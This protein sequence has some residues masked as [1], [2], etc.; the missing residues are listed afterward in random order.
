[1]VQYICNICNKEFVRKKDLEYH[2]IHK[3]KPCRVNNILIQNNPDE[4]K[5]IQNKE[6]FNQNNQNKENNK[7]FSCNFCNKIFFN[8]SNLNKHLKNNSCKV[9]KLQD[10]EKE[11]IFKILLAKDEEL[12]TQKEF[13]KN[14]EENNKELKEYIKNITNMNLDLNNKVNKLIEKI[15]VGNIN[16]GVINNNNNNINNINN[17]IITTDQLCNFGS[18]DIKQIDSKLFKNLNGKF[19]K[20]IFLECAKNIYNNLSKNKTLYFSDLSREKAMAWDNG[21]WNLIPMNKAINTINDQIRAYFKHNEENYERL[22][23]PEV[24]KHYDETI[25]KYYKMYYQEYDKTDKFEPAQSRLDEFNRV[26]LN[27]LK[28]FFYNIKEDVKNN[29]DQIQKKILDSNLLK[30]IEY[31]PEKKPRGRPKKV[32]TNT[33]TNTTPIP[34]PI[35]IPIKNDFESD[36]DLDPDLII[37]KKSCK[38]KKY[39]L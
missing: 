12:K 7:N 23:I 16:K 20:E 37:I 25:K 39:L 17:I 3:K 8:N 15:S 33:N 36:L 28:E 14:L 21:K 22:K 4:S 32:I 18:E 9:K 11:N 24:K 1:M 31:K 29:Y 19:G 2:Q 27:G 30:K 38:N 10:E 5:I 35:Q 34:I 26:V 6:I 13:N